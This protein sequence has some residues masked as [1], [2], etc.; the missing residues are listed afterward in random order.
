MT[1][2]AR[3]APIATQDFNLALNFLRPKSMECMVAPTFPG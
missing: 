1:E 2:F 3:I